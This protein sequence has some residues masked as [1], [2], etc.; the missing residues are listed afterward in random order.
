MRE[1]KEIKRTNY[2]IS[3][4]GY[5][6]NKKTGHILSQNKTNGNGYIISCL[7]LKNYYNH[8]LVGEY[9]VKNPDDKSIINHIDGNKTNNHHSNLEWVS[10][11]EN[12]QH[13]IK[14]LG[15]SN[16]GRSLSDSDKEHLSSMNKGKRLGN[17]NHKS[18]P[19]KC[20]ETGVIFQSAGRAAVWCGRS[21]KKGSYIGRVCNGIRKSC[22]G[23]T[24]EWVETS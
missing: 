4:D 16:K 7:H 23:Y 6:R 3:N 18:K 19:V 17:S 21:N 10:Q 2:E 20:I 8:R 11:N 14:V 24:W 13:S 12:I 1:W 9:F 22:F 15:N 5:V